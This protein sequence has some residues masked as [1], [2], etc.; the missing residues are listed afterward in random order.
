[1]NTNVLLNPKYPV[2]EKYTSALQS[3]EGRPQ[4]WISHNCCQNDAWYQE[5]EGPWL[6]L[7]E[8]NQEMM[9]PLELTWLLHEGIVSQL[10]RELSVV[11]YMLPLLPLA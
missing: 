9:S 7:H 10:S 8:P 1:M 2:A 3:K 5:L 11:A 6:M 4:T